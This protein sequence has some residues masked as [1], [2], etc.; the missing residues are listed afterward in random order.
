MQAMETQNLRRVII[1]F[2]QY[3]VRD[4]GSLIQCNNWLSVFAHAAKKRGHKKERR[5]TPSILAL[6]FILHV[7]FEYCVCMCDTSHQKSHL[8]VHCI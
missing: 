5:V 4:S 3:C 6:E 2:L 7:A 8:K 1:G